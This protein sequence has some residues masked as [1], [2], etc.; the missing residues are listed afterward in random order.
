MLKQSV[1]PVLST[2][3]CSAKCNLLCSLCNPAGA[4]ALLQAAT[5]MLTRVLELDSNDAFA[6]HTLGQMHEEQGRHTDALASYG[7]GCQCTGNLLAATPY[8]TAVCTLHMLHQPCY[9]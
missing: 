4:P 9:T 3:S 6:W 2:P 1:L 8:C 5:D 7:R